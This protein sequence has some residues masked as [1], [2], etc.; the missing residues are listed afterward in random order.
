M[1][2]IASVALAQAPTAGAA[3]GGAS[4]APG[5]QAGYNVSLTD[6]NGFQQALAKVGAR[7]EAQPVNV[8]GQAA[9]MLFQP[10]EHINA[11]ATQLAADAQIAQAVGKDL[12]P[13]AMIAFSARCQ[14]FMFHSQLLSNM[15]NRTS[16]GLQ[17]L[18]RQQS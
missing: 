2:E 12:S 10:F 4:F 18:F 17:Q 15:A 14:E 7:L 13:G 11:S 1:T 3:T 16:D 8:P 5:V 6:F 9:Q